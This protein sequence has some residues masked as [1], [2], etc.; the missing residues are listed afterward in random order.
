MSIKVRVPPALTKG[1]SGSDT[2]EMSVANLGELLTG[3]E[4]RYPGVKKSICDEAGKLNRFINVFV[5]DEDI[6]F[7]GGEQ[8]QF[9]DGDEVLLIPSIAGG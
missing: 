9:Q 7:L 1:A 8:Y 6:R 4:A 5:N 3:L 2:L